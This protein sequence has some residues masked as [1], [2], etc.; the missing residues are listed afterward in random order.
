MA[1]LFAPPTSGNITTI[2]H[3]DLREFHH[4][5]KGNVTIQYKEVSIGDDK[6]LDRS[7]YANVIC[8]FTVHLITE[9]GKV[10]KKK[11]RRTGVIG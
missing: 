10:K 1:K 8:I 11:R 2:L 7:P 9:G 3:S 4:S 6:I 5:E